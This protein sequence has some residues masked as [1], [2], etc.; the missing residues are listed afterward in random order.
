MIFS[1]VIPAYNEEKSVLNI[2]TRAK[3]AAH[4][5][6]AAGI[7]VSEIE[8]LLINDGSADRTED[9]AKTIP[10]IT[11]ISHPVNRGY[12]A[13]IKTGFSRARGELL[14][15]LD[16]DGTCDPIFF[17]PLIT[18][19]LRE[20]LDM[21]VG[22]RLH[23]GTKMPAI[24]KLGNRIFRA[25]VN[26]IGS[27]SSTD[28][29]SGMRVLRKQAL[30]RLHPL[31]DGLNFTPAM[32]VRAILDCRLKLAEI[33]MPYEDRVG[34]S[35][36]RVVNDGLRFLF[37]ILET[38]MTYRPR[39]FFGLA[40]IAFAAL[41][42]WA[43]IAKWGALQSPLFYY[44]EHGRL[45]NWMIFR[46]VFVSWCVTVAVF[47]A[48]FGVT[49]QSLVSVI[50]EEDVRPKSKILAAGAAVSF[51]TGMYFSRRMAYAYFSTGAI[52]ADFWIFIIAGSL[53]TLVSIE[54]FAFALLDHIVFLIKERTRR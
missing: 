25:I 13:A 14:G 20:N 18:L 29:A 30:K 54:M 36:L 40:A 6:K 48:A 46:C 16:A 35:K 34:K 47:L 33:P 12:G 11:L 39:F 21:A 2:L 4:K 52:S 53:F 32:S 28:I 5:I 15:F 27:S 42:L 45:R 23:S 1:I 50:N 3:D 31:P 7:G 17:I 44:L 43:L 24:R 19:C 49:S 37:V 10:G 22:S 9:I 41:G 51:L 38:A 26:T 8:I